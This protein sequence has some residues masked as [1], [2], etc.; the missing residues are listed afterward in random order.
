PSGAPRSPTVSFTV[1]GVDSRTVATRLAADAGVFA[2]NGN[3]YAA[4]IA[5]RYG[6]GGSGW[7]RAGCACYT[8]AEEVERLVRA[9]RVISAS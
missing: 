8:T 9:V 6:I 7:V 2:S 1:G 4:T 3:F 5:Q